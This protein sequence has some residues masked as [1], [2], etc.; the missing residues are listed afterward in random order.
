MPSV[1]TSPLTA[2]Q[3]DGFYLDCDVSGTDNINSPTF[4]YQWRMNDRA[5][6]LLDQQG[7]TLSLSPLVTS[8]AGQ[9]TCQVTVGSS[10]LSSNITVTSNTQTVNIQRKYKY[11][12][13]SHSGYVI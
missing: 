10:S 5:L 4:T 6:E 13:L 8:H 3:T 1:N 2:G 12:C 11:S 9:Y 7:R